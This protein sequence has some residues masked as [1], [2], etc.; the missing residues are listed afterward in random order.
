MTD[1]NV[2]TELEKVEKELTQEQKKLVSI[3]Q[4][5]QSLRD[6]GQEI[7]NNIYKLTGRQEYLQTLNGKKP[8][9]KEK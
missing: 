1:V 9:A 3:N 5:V 8:E 2:K 4:Q 6:A 7:I